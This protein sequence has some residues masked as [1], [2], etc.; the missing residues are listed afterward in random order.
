MEKELEKPAQIYQSNGLFEYLLVAS[1]DDRVCAK[2][3]AEKEYF[4]ANYKIKG[5]SKALPH[6]TLANFFAW[7]RMEDTFLRYLQRIGGD[8]NSFAVTLNN[9]S[10]LPSHTIFLCVQDPVQFEVLATKLRAISPYIKGNKLPPGQ[11]ITN[12]HM[13][14]ARRLHTIIYKEAMEEYSSKPFNES[15][16]VTELVLLRRQHQ[17]D[18]CKRVAVF[19][20]QPTE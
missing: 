2:I 3:M 10:G 8:Q 14:I 17:Y 9:Y 20:L 11:F 19:S 5:A 6:I 7:D 16:K 13:T 1:P 15:F 4:S 18:Q 12:P